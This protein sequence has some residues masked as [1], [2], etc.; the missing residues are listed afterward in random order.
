MSTETERVP[1]SMSDNRILKISS[2]IRG[3]HA[4][5]NWWTPTYGEILPLQPELE[6]AEDKNAVAVLKESRVIGHITFH[7]A[8]TKNRTGIVTHFISKPTNQ[9]SVEVCGKAVNRDG[10]LGMEIPCVYT[11]DGP[12]KHV[13]LLEQLLDVSNN[14]AIRAED[15]HGTARSKQTTS[16]R[17]RV[18]SNDCN[19]KPRK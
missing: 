19:K 18:K 5:K 4:Y 3:F 11:F 15:D 1:K 13:D 17:K 16:K 2:W 10:D 7:L 9:G 8:N 6:N 14:P 12:R